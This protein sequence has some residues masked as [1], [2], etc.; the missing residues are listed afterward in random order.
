M[1]ETGL[2]LRGPLVQAVLAGRKTQHRML[3]K[4]QPPFGCIYGINGA[5]SH[6]ICCA[7]DN[8]AVWVPPTPKSKDHRL[9]CPYGKPGDR[10]WVKETWGMSFEDIVPKGRQFISGGTWGSQDR[11]HRKPCVVFLSDGDMPSNSPWET[12]RWSPSTQMPR[13]ASRITLEIISVRVDRLQ[14]IA[15]EDAI[16]EGCEME[17]CFPKEQPDQSGIGEIGWDSAV[18]WYSWIWESIHGPD[19]WELNPYVWVIEFKEVKS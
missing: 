5:Q 18:E 3:V 2:I 17:G 1:K 14:D 16:A 8:H 15:E 19:S 12:A 13:W 11:P 10:L 4:P 9:P 7:A 6:A